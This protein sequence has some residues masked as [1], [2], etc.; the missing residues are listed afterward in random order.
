ME[1]INIHSGD[2]VDVNGTSLM[3]HVTTNYSDLVE[4]FGEPTHTS[5]GDKVHIEW[6]VEF[7]V[8]DEYRDEN[9]IKATI[10]D[11]KLDAPEYGEYRW[12]IGGHSGDAAFLVQDAL[13]Q[14]KVVH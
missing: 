14:R 3:G 11:W 8:V 1:I 12:H 4:A 13:E 2:D 7:T 10:Y 9:V 6:D 5:G